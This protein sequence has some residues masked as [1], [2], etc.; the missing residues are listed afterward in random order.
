[1]EKKCIERI[2]SINAK[3]VKV[4][5]NISQYHLDVQGCERQKV[6]LAAQLFSERTAL[7]IEWYGQKGYLNNFDW[8]ETARVIRLFN[9]WFDIFNASSMYGKH[10]G[11]N[12][13]GINLEKQDDILREMTELT[14]ETTIGKHKSLITF[15]KGIIV[16]NCSLQQFLPYI[17]EMY[18]ND[19]FNVQYIITRRLNQD[20][21]E[22][23]FSFIRAT[24]IAYDKPTAL[25]FKY[26]LKRYIL[27]KHSTNLF[28]N[29]RACN[30]SAEPDLPCFVSPF[31][32]GEANDESGEVLS[33]KILEPYALEDKLPHFEEEELFTEC[34][35]TNNN[36]IV[37]DLST[38][39]PTLE[40]KEFLTSIDE[41]DIIDT[42][43]DE[44]LKYIAGYVAH[45]FKSKYSN[46]GV[47]TFEMPVGSDIEWVQ[48]ISRGKCMYPSEILLTATRI[49]NV[50]FEKYHGSQLRK[51]KFIFNELAT[52]VQEKI[53]PLKLPR[54]VILCLVRTRTYIRLRVM[55]R[56]ISEQNR[57]KHKKMKIIKFINNKMYCASLIT[58]LSFSFPLL[59]FKFLQF[60]SLVFSKL[61]FLS[62]ISYICSV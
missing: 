59:S 57:N 4:S 58:S 34:N 12:A 29:E 2:L 8:K 56:Q 5:H 17:K 9:D 53:Q 18:S 44:G 14:N 27:G 11:K 15:Q 32:T 43:E 39:H 22:N 61:Q 50:E 49:M 60:S 24:G 30:V 31:I 1:V 54:T 25:D 55:N 48:F 52:I 47:A 23:F 21:L 51:N 37:C 26:R 35:E 36:V 33:T 46:L 38:F 62:C 40:E 16:N 28:C 19:Y 7:A 10:D 41:M 6:V 3:D 42:I 45:R 20:V 13:Y